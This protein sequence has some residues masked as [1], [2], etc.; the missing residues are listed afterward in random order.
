MQSLYLSAYHDPKQRIPNWIVF[1]F[2]DKVCSL[3]SIWLRQLKVAQSRLLFHYLQLILI[4]VTTFHRDILVALRISCISR[5]SL[6]NLERPTSYLQK[7]YLV[8]CGTSY[9][10][11]LWPTWWQYKLKIFN[12]SVCPPFRDILFKYFAGYPS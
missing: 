10:T 2:S 3:A 12:F 11:L 4:F 6:L 8:Y 7:S 1:I 5:F 9:L